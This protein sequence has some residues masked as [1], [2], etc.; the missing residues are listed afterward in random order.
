MPILHQLGSQGEGSAIILFAVYQI[1]WYHDL[2]TFVFY[3]VIFWA[4]SAT[5]V[6]FLN[7][8][9]IM[10]LDCPFLL[11]SHQYT[12]SVWYLLYTLLELLEQEARRQHEENFPPLRLRIIFLFN[13]A[14]AKS[15]TRFYRVHPSIN[16][17]QKIPNSNDA[18]SSNFW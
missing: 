17:V 10:S 4:Q 8:L 18:S 7:N 5:F 16:H 6:N 2:R 11:I 9:Q 12:E 15:D 14:Y 1:Y 3:I 13:L